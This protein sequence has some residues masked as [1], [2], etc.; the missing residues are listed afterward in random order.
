MLLFKSLFF[1]FV[2]LISACGFEP[3][4]RYQH[5]DAGININM[6]R[7]F[8]N[9]IEG[10]IGQMVRN[11]LKDRMN[12]YGTP[13]KPSYQLYI[14]IEEPKVSQSISLDNT[15]SR[16]KMVYKAIYRLIKNNETIIEDETVAE[17]S[18][19]ILTMPYAT[20]VS[21]EDAIRRAA[22]ILADD[23]LLRVSVYF[24]DNIN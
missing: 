5:N 14:E 24:R 21:Q 17:A 4:Y 3:L 18:Y 13:Q 2:L 8:I 19:S 15:A 23:I 1:A 12:T 20:I 9:P 22:A 10:R 6:A 16:E 7:T 11:N